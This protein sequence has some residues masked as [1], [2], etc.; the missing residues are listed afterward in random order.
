MS[1][2]LSISCDVADIATE[3]RTCDSFNELINELSEY[4]DDYI[5]NSDEELTDKGKA[6]IKKMAKQIEEMEKN[7]V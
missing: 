1:Q 2:Y 4:D 6:L 7:D 5:K 3:I